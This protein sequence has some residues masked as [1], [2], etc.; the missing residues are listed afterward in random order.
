MAISDT[1][2]TDRE[3]I[4]SMIHCR[5][6]YGYAGQITDDF[7][8]Q[9]LDEALPDADI[10]EYANKLLIEHGIEDA[11]NATEILTEWRNSMPAK[12]AVR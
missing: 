11:D 10:A 2:T 5:F 8:W 4:I 7:F 6:D 3:N 9:I 12:E 1:V